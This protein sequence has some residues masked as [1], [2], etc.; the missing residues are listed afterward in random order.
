MNK[1]IKCSAK[2]GLEI[3][4]DGSGNIF[5]SR[6]GKVKIL[7]CI[8]GSEARNQCNRVEFEELC[9]GME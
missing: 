5:S 1:S 8:T 7:N 4:M 6:A 2:N 9:N 3:L